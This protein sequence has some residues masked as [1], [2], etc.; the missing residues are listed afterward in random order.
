MCYR[1]HG[2]PLFMVH[3]DWNE[4]FTCMVFNNLVIVLLIMQLKKIVK[5]DGLFLTAIVVTALWDI[6]FLLTLFLNPGIKPH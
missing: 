3:D 5:A 1:G 4:P 6:C 2:R